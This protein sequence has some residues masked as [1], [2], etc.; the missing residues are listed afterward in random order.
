MSYSAKWNGVEYKICSNIRQLN[1][2]IK[3]LQKKIKCDINDN[4]IKESL[5]QIEKLK[6]GMILF[7]IY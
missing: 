4:K 2:H 3:A 7:S 6:K 1:C 5:L